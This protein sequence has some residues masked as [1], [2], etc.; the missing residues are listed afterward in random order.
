MFMNLSWHGT[1]NQ[2]DSLKGIMG[3]GTVWKTIVHF[4]T[5]TFDVHPQTLLTPLD[6]S[7]SSLL[8]KFAVKF[9][10]GTRLP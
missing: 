3:S 5:L 10:A 7:S 9:S 4:K 8:F 2:C 1:K 6:P